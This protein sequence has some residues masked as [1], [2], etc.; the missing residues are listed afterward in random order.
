MKGK[1]GG[2]IEKESGRKE[3][4]WITWSVGRMGY[5]RII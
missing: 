1:Y 3:E 5:D 2:D 4:E